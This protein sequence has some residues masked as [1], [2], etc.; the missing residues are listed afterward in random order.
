MSPNPE[1]VLAASVQKAQQNVPAGFKQHPSQQ[2][3]DSGDEDR[4]P[5]DRQ[6]QLERRDSE[7]EEKFKAL[8]R[9]GSRR[10]QRAS[11]KREQQKSQ[12]QK[13]LET[14]QLLDSA[15]TGGAGGSEFDAVAGFLNSASSQSGGGIGHTR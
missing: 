6:R 4:I 7:R 5:A 15:E 13:A 3:A 8:E 14:A 11:F 1:V 2:D 10:S 9:T 12:K